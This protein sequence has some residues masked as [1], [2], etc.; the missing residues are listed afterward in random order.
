MDRDFIKANLISGSPALLTKNLTIADLQQNPQLQTADSLISSLVGDTP[1]KHGWY[2]SLS[3]KSDG[4]EVSGRTP[5]A[6]KAFEEAIALTDNL[7]IPV[8]DPEGTGINAAGDPCLP[9]IIGES[10]W[11]QYCLPFG[12]CLT[13]SGAKDSV[14]ESKTGFKLDNDGKNSNVIG[15]GIRGIALAPKTIT[16]NGGNTGANSCGGITLSGNAGGTGEWSCT[17]RLI[18]TRWYEKYQ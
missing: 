7:F 10:D 15:S 1:S 4:T 17:T 13:S 3:S 8:Y 14:Q 16:N 11:Q 18:P 12:V 6:M 2:R 9:R 5:G